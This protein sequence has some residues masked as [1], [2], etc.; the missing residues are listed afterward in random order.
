MRARTPLVPNRRGT[1]ATL[2]IALAACSGGTETPGGGDPS[3]GTVT[4]SAVPTSV[5]L[6]TGGTRSV[7]LTIVRT[8]RTDALTLSATGLPTGV[9]VAFNPAVL[10]GSTLSS[11]AT[12]TTDIDAPAPV[13][14]GIQI[15]VSAADGLVVASVLLQGSVS[16]PTLFVTRTG[17]G[18]GTVTSNPGGIN[19]G[20]ACSTNYAPGTIVT[21]TATPAAGSAFGGWS[22]GGCS[23]TAT[24]CA[25]TMTGGV[26]STTVIATFNS[27]AQSF[28]VSVTPTTAALPQGGNTTATVNITRLNGYAGA[29]TLTTSGAPS[30]L[31]VSSNPSSTTGNTA[32]LN[33]AAT[34]AV[35][36]G[37][38]PLTVSATGAGITGAQTTTLNVQVTAGQGGSGNLAFSFGACDPSELPIWFAVQNGTGVWTQVTAGANGTFTF[39]P[40]SAGGVAWVMPDG[41][42]FFTNV[43]YMTR[44]EFTS[45]A[46]GSQCAGLHA[47]TGTKR[48][49]G[50]TKGVVPNGVVTVTVGAAAVEAGGSTA[51]FTLDGVPAGTRDLVAQVATPNA[52]GTFQFPKIILRRN[53]NYAST[54]PDL[55]F[56]GADAV[57]TQFS[58][59]GTNNRGTDATG[60]TTSFVTANGSSAEYGNNLGGP[61]A[62]GYAGVPD[63]LLLPGD[64]HEIFVTASPAGGSSFRAALVLRHSVGADAVT[65]GPALSQPTVASVGT[66]PYLRLRAQLVSQAE[67]NAIAHVDF[68]QAANSASVTTTAGYSNGT[69]ATWTITIPDL[70]AAGYDPA[71]G[72]KTGS[73][74]D[75]LA[76]AGAGSVLPLL[77]STPN[78]GDRALLA[79]VGSTSSAFNRL[80]AFTMRKR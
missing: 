12:F 52:N 76:L 27:T 6:T 7:T 50:T 32:T 60:M 3:N 53:V 63:S 29:V 59:I 49:T 33:V 36:V 28:S 56:N 48:L 66:S 14:A 22:G 51:P 18:S 21:L 42:N 5:A 79:A 9:T 11:T 13:G 67:Y 40:G 74:V 24:T 70:T 62:V 69:P 31:T 75:W 35:A 19:C 41:P 17:T 78:D 10:T 61:N 68:A 43:M 26:A 57:F 8:N 46:L 38:Y 34:T 2:L 80:P 16:R 73:A 77:G 23:G 45:L 25:I 4:I 55:D 37:N 44:A 47:S 1:A 15:N 64:L 30:G 20:A 39:D 71:W 58:T 72:M 65:F 54:I